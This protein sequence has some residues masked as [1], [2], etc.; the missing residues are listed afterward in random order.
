MSDLN[1]AGID[2]NLLLLTATVLETQSATRAAKRLHVTQSAVSNA[3]RRARELFG[4]PLVTRQAHGF[5]VTSRGAALLPR[6]KVWLEQARQLVSNEPGFDPNTTHRVF[7]IACTDAVALVLLGPLVRLLRDHAPNASLRFVTLDRLIHEDALVRGEVDLLVGAPPYVP[8]A[9]RA[10]LVY[11]DPFV[12]L[13]HRSSGR[14][15][16]LAK[17]AE[18]PHVELALFGEVDDAVDQALA[19]RDRRREVKVAVASFGLVPQAVLESRGVCTLG[20]RVAA[21]FA[22][23]HRQLDCLP[24]PVKLP[25]LRVEQ[26]W[27][28]RAEDDEGV[29][30]LRRLV[31]EAADLS[32]RAP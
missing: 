31:R 13:V 27:H 9:H 15:L 32:S 4:D 20:Q 11:V 1:L 8:P 14:G 30:F 25:P 6:L 7:S 18:L 16:S 3:L 22:R 24:C 12:C 23:S 10:E 2:L 19:I 26:V 5:R 28:S 17:Y 21:R 29:R